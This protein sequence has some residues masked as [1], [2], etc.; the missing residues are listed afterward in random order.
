MRRN[1]SK[2]WSVIQ[3]LII[4][5]CQRFFT[6]HFPVLFDVV[7]LISAVVISKDSSEFDAITF[8]LNNTSAF[9]NITIDLRTFNAT[10]PANGLFKQGKIRIRSDQELTLKTS[11]S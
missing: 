4:S 5:L 9:S 10:E 11:A 3:V 8:A 7:F 6:S 1:I 2:M